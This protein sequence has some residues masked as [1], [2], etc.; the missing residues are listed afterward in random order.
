MREVLKFT[1]V[2]MAQVRASR[3]ALKNRPG[4]PDKQKML[5]LYY[6][7]HE[8]AYDIDPSS[9]S[10]A[11]SMVLLSMVRGAIWTPVYR[12]VIACVLRNLR[13]LCCPNIILVFSRLF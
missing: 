9:K 12:T 2:S 7:E 3:D 8:R 10:S 6:N 11:N 13:N 4:T 1:L 5:V